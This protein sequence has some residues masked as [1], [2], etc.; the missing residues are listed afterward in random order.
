MIGSD[1][2]A[3]SSRDW[4]R[5]CGFCLDSLPLFVASLMLIVTPGFFGH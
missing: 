4:F 5:G 3:R 2:T 1:I